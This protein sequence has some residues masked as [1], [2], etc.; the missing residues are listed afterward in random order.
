MVVCAVA[1]VYALTQA[2]SA[3]A[4]E[5]A[6]ASAGPEAS[7]AT[8]SAAATS[9][10][11]RQAGLD[12]KT[13]ATHLLD[14]F[15][16]G[17]RP[18]DV[19]TVVAM[20]LEAWLEA[21]LA[22]VAEPDLEQRLEHLPSL[23]M[24][25]RQIQRTYLS[26]F[27]LR[28]MLARDRSA[29]DRTVEVGAGAG[30][31]QDDRDA[32]EGTPARGEAS[33]DVD[34]V[35]LHDEVVAWAK[36]HGLRTHK[37][38]VAELASQKLLRAVYSPNQLR[39]VM[40]AFWLDHFHV[41]VRNAEVRAFAISYDADAVRPRALGEFGSL[42]F[43]TAAHPAMLV[44][45]DNARSVAEAA[46]PRAFD[47]QSY[48]DWT[49]LRARFASLADYASAG[50]EAAGLN[51][52]YARELL[53]LHTLGVQGGYSEQDV[54]EI[55]RAF[56]GWTVRSSAGALSPYSKISAQ[57]LA[58]LA[59]DQLQVRRQYLFRGDLHDAGPKTVLGQALPAGRGARDGRDVLWL[60]ARHPSTA[61]HVARKLAIRFVSD[62][63]PEALV[64]QLA[65]TF[66]ATGGDIRALLRAIARSP[67]FWSA[68]ARGAKVK[69]PFE[70]AASALRGLDAEVKSPLAVM[71]RVADMGQP[72][73]AASAPT[74]FPDQAAAWL[75]AGT[76][77]AR[78]RFGLDLAAGRIQ[79]ISV[80]LGR[81]AGGPAPASL[82]QA[83]AAYGARLLPGRDAKALQMALRELLAAPGLDEGLVA[84]AALGSPEPAPPGTLIA[85]FDFEAADVPP[86]AVLAHLAGLILG[87]S[88]FQR[89]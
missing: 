86:Q 72:A 11:W 3:P 75:D 19:D 23:Q 85:L 59:P 10:P 32:I 13:A 52:N 54:R 87:S 76:L 80:D 71:R 8:A 27:Q 4:Q 24:S 67:H 78:L 70:L 22:P 49:E 6:R 47:P 30:A 79:G 58:R 84:A 61:R 12:A 81:L 68:A 37:H 73:Y 64:D 38:L 44:Y 55:A 66:E 18:G 28:N 63:P 41:S 48:P 17:P 88:E 1:G 2:A 20:G 21:Q 42:L 7:A 89:R 60:L 43:A 5:D 14:R 53:E 45:L 39:E 65:A 16:Y 9:F 77:L 83:F 51:E 15:A 74:G 57:A 29:A 40:T 31:A 36:S 69:Q 82:D 33:D 25:P 56:T 34:H 62:A 46:A 26:S 35:L 50:R